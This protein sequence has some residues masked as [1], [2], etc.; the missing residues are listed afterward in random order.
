MSMKSVYGRIGNDIAAFRLKWS[1]STNC[2]TVYPHTFGVSVRFE[3]N[4]RVG[5]SPI[6][7]RK[8]FGTNNYHRQKSSYAD[9][10][11]GNRTGEPISVYISG[12][13]IDRVVHV[14]LHYDVEL[15]QCVITY[16]RLQPSLLC[17]PWLQV[18]RTNSGTE[19]P[20]KQVTG[21]IAKR[22]C[23]T[24]QPVAREEYVARDKVLSSPPWY[25]KCKIKIFIRAFLWQS[26]YRT[27]RQ[28]WKLVMC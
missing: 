24:V 23:H 4:I 16:R 9:I 6:R 2:T 8:T 14:W 27:A 21:N 15:A 28:F 18:G 7:P 13:M 3:G 17:R 26:L 12:S 20:E 1:A 5:G 11:A 10:L 25:L 19:Q 22:V